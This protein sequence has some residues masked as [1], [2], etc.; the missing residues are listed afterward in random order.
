MRPASLFQA[1]RLLPVTPPA[2]EYDESM[3]K[4]ITVSLP[5]DLVAEAE[6]AVAIGRSPNVSAYVARAMS[7][8]RDQDTLTELIADMWSEGARPTGADYT[9]ASELLGFT[10]KPS[11]P[12]SE[13]GTMGVAS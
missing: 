3:T 11:V 5:D 2:A 1:T 10:V 7:E 9:R 12:V 6:H 13:E 4:R 8:Q